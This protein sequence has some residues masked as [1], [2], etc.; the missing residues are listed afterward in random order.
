MLESLD[1]TLC[2]VKDEGFATVANMKRSDGCG[3]PHADHVG[4]AREGQWAGASRGSDLSGT[5]I[6]D[7]GVAHLASLRQL[8]R[9]QLASTNITDNALTLSPRCPRSGTQSPI[10]PRS[11]TRASRGWKKLA[12]L[13]DVDVR[14]TRATAAGSRS[15][16]AGGR[17]RVA[18]SAPPATR[19]VPAPGR[20][21]LFGSRIGGTI[22]AD[23]SAVSLLGTAVSDQNLVALGALGG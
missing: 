9:L 13:R 10:A 18:F 19:T 11:P 6:D 4:V 1:I 14:Y 12:K 17:I 23:G 16:S 15:H 3:R 5:D 21:W 20:T 2:P 22:S 8:R 7:A